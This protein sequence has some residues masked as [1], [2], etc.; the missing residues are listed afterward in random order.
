MRFVEG[1]AS[2]GCWTGRRS[3]E[4]PLA[5]LGQSDRTSEA[6]GGR[7]GRDWT[8]KR[9]ECRLGHVRSVGAH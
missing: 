8:L 1:G 9:S 4:E 2:T 5:A 7:K 3:G 6:V